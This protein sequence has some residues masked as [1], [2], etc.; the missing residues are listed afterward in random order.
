V[1]PGHGFLVNLREKEMIYGYPPEASA[2]WEFVYMAF[3]GGNSDEV[4]REVVHR[5]GVVVALPRENEIERHIIRISSETEPSAILLT[6]TFETSSLILTL[7]DLICRHQ[8][9]SLAESESLLIRQGLE[10]IRKHLHAPYN[11][12]ML[13]LELGFSRE[14]LTRQFKKRTGKTPHDV[15]ADAKMEEALRLLRTTFDTNLQI[16]QRL[17]FSNA[18]NFARQF[19]QHAGM[20]PREYRDRTSK[21]V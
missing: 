3:T 20:T 11:T 9:E 14:H 2:A 7:M 16:A 5:H 8:T 12:K 17:G 10:L 13:A 19:R 6:R 15:I 21:S 1:P 18:Q 4:L